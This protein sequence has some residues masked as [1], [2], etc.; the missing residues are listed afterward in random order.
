MIFW[1]EFSCWHKSN[2]NLA[3]LLLYWSY[4]YKSL[5]SCSRTGWSLQ[6]INRDFFSTITNKTFTEFDY[7]S[8][9]A[10]VLKESET[11]YP[12]KTPGFTLFSFFYFAGYVLLIILFCGVR[13][14][15]HFILRGTCYS[16]FYFLCC[17][18][19]FVYLC[20]VSSAYYCLFLYSWLRSRFFLTFIS[21]SVKTILQKKENDV[22]EWL[23]FNAKWEV[24]QLYHGENKLRYAEMMMISLFVLSQHAKLDFYSTISLS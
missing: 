1:T 4:R 15:H 8:N 20:F 2:S 3:T 5:Q 19:G 16:S 23:L 24:F 11:A 22:N 9:L 7:M 18:F 17:V 13:V 12:P 6:N 14:T 10:D 21:R